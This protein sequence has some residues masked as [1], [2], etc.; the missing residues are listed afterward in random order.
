MSSSKKFPVK[1][2][3][4]VYLSEAPSLY[5]PITPPP[6]THCIRVHCILVHTVRG[7]GIANQREGWRG[8]S[9][10]CWVKNTNT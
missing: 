2:A 8:N 4:G 1:F 10:Q 6:P 5:D 7:G 9:S 3:A